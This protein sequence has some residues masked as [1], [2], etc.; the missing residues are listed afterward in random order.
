M[1][2]A[3]IVEALRQIDLDFVLITRDRNA[4]HGAEMVSASLDRSGSSQHP[5]LQAALLCRGLQQIL[6]YCKYD[7]S[8][9]SEM[10]ESV[11]ELNNR[12]AEWY[13]ASDKRG[14]E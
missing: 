4:A 14:N 9:A 12:F 3:E 11:V 7:M 8:W 5:A 1:E 6:N 2:L 13:N 10:S